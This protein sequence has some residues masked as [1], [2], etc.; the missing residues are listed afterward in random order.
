MRLVRPIPN[1][2][3]ESKITRIQEGLEGHAAQSP[4]VLYNTSPPGRAASSGI[5]FRC[6][7]ELRRWQ[8]IKRKDDATSARL[9]GNLL[10]LQDCP[11]R[12]W[13]PYRLWKMMLFVPFPRFLPLESLTFHG[14]GVTAFEQA[15]R[16]IWL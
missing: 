8:S 11:P 3:L 14:L 12:P 13:A 10:L 16:F 9:I 15:R 4:V 7:I 2:E 5:L 6:V 1:L